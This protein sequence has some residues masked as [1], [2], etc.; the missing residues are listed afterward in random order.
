MSCSSHHSESNQY[1]IDYDRKELKK[2]RE[3]TMWAPGNK[4]YQMEKTASESPCSGHVPGMLMNK[5]FK[6]GVASLLINSILG[7]ENSQIPHHLLGLLTL[8]PQF[9]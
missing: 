9:P 1:N 8:E 5:E 7:R 2:V 3:Q 4:I 6:A